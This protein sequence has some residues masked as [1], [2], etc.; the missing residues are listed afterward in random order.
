MNPPFLVDRPLRRAALRAV[1]F[2]MHSLNIGALWSGIFRKD[3]WPRALQAGAGIR[4]DPARRDVLG[5]DLFPLEKGR[6]TCSTAVTL[7]SSSSGRRHS[8]RVRQRLERTANRQNSESY[9]Y[10]PGRRA[11]AASAGS[12]MPIRCQVVF[13]CDPVG[14]G[15][16]IRALLRRAASRSNQVG[17]GL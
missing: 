5:R 4:R 11:C 13:R 1:I 8:N 2:A 6:V 9:F 14:D 12:R 10:D 3:Q 15:A 17:P 16:R 7:V